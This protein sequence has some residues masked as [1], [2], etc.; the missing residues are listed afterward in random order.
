MTDEKTRRRV[1]QV[2]GVSIAGLL[3]GC[4]DDSSDEDPGGLFSTAEPTTDGEPSPKRTTKTTT[5]TTEVETETPVETETTIETVEPI[6]DCG[7]EYP[8]EPTSSEGEFTL[9][10]GRQESGTRLIQGTRVLFNQNDSHPT[11]NLER[12]PSSG[13][14]DQL[15]TSIPAG[16][17]P[18]IFQWNHDIAGEF[19]RSDLLSDQSSNLRVGECAFTDNAWNASNY[20]GQTV[21]LPFA[22]ECPAL[23]YNKEILDDMGVEPPN[24]FDEWISIME[25]Y[26]DPQDG[27]YGLA[28]PLNAYFVSWAAQAYGA[29]IYNGQ[30][31]ELGITSDEAI[32]GLNLILEDLKPFMPADPSEQAQMSVFQNGD[33]P[34]LVNGPW[35]IT[36][37]EEAGLNVDAMPIPVPGDGVARPYSGVQ[38]VFFSRKMNDYGADTRAAREFAEW[39]CTNVERIR[40]LARN[41]SYVPVKTG[42]GREQMSETTRGFAAQFETS[43]PMPQNPKMNSVWVPFETRVLNA[44]TY[45]NDPG[46]L[47]EEA[48]EEIRSTWA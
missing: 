42:L 46:P 41:A 23:I 22:G 13:Y 5:T 19:V 12:G 26:H 28:H 32:Q 9:L 3:A 7:H 48:A 6:D 16:E 27:R 31:D 37:L 2:G 36:D 38:L 17:G 40:N 35:T 8:L 47:M 33:S 34:F 45:G 14:L 43:Y 18:Q 24:T 10:H 21:G 11:M 15:R 20:D 39:Y 29:D 30:A 25:E 1:L 44:F 4:S